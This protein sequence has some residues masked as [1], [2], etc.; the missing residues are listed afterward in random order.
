[1]AQSPGF[2][3]V[4]NIILARCATCHRPGEAAPFSLLTYDDIAKRASFIKQV[5]QTGYMP[6]WRADA[7]YRDFANNRSLTP[8]ERTLLLRWIDAG[9]PKPKGGDDKNTLTA[10]T[11]Y[12]RAPDLTLKI[13]SPFL[14][15]GDDAERFVVFKL[16]YTLPADR[17]IEAV[18]FYC[19]N[20]R[21][22]HHINY[23]FYAVP[24]TTVSITGGSPYIDADKP[25]PQQ[26]EYDPLKKNFTYYTGW[27]PGTSYESYPPGFGWT[28]SHRGVVLLTVHYT[29]LGADE[30]SIVGVN[31][32]F[33]PKP[34]RRQVKI[35]SLGSGGIGEEDITPPLL[36]RAGQI[37][38]FQFSVKTQEE[39]SLLYVWPHMH[40]IGKEF[41]AWAQTPAG[42]TIPLVHIPHWDFRWQELYRMKHLVRLP[43]GSIVHVQGVYDNTAQNPFNPNNPPRLVLSTGNMSSRD[44][45]LTL[46]MIYVAAEDGDEK[47]V[48]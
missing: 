32:F 8:D 11:A 33:S 7:H 6:P 13:D 5:I 17:N 37:D 10:N 34:I 27:I 20:K 4:H 41:T 22:I 42:D 35:I 29:A 25:G 40:Y 24:D 44:E 36:I 26:A 23:G 12:A 15:P 30:H 39:Q 14:V 21:I 28:L 48:L 2:A 16:P 18:E 1:M 19:N 45:M 9:A 43:A 38:T 3:E 31:L 47:T 46:L